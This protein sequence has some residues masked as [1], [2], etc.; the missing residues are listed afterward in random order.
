MLT[1]RENE[2]ESERERVI[3]EQENMREGPLTT[4]Y[5]VIFILKHDFP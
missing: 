5:L 4:K 1:G 2:R 3:S